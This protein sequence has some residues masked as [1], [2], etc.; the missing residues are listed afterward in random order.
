MNKIVGLKDLCTPS[1]AYLVISVTALIIMTVQNYGNA[2][3]Y[4]LGPYKCDD[5]NT[6]M[7]FIV[8]LLYV[9]FWTWLLN[10]MCRGGATNF[11]WF[12]V[13]FPFILMFVMLGMFVLSS[14]PVIPIA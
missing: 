11:A 12:L 10:V 7:V 6:L 3:K 1:Y 9:L 2:D 4:C 13:L 5:T 8:K 14:T